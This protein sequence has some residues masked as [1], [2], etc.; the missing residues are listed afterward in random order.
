VRISVFGLGYVGTVTAACL[1]RDGHQII[2]VDVSEA[3]VETLAA[4]LSPIVEPGLSDLLARAAS[5]SELSAMTDGRE[6]VLHS[7]VSLISVGTPPQAGG[8]ARP[9]LRGARVPTDR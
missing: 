3:K 6:A 4:G 5:R 8:S 1:A 2:G 7:V 9:H